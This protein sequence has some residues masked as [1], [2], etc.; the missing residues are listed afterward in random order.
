MSG[1]VTT[2]Y[3]TQFRLGLFNVYI[4][5]FHQLVLNYFGQIKVTNEGNLQ[6]QAIVRCSAN[7]DS[8]HCNLLENEIHSICQDHS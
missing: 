7:I 2:F 5:T 1:L 3:K 4:S 6:C 8:I